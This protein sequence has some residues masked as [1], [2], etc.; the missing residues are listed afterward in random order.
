MEKM[1]INEAIK[2]I[3]RE[4]KMRQQDMAAAIGKKRAQ[5]VSSRLL[6]KNMT[7]DRAIEMLTVMGYEV[8][9]QPRKAGKRPDGQYV[10][11][12]SDEAEATVSRDGA[13]SD[14]VEEK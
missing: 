11:V 8:T 12:K 9:V 3:M 4:K 6:S 13:K 14:E 2:A 10:I 5:D 7:F 1:T